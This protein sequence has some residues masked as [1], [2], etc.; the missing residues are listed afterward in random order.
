[1]LKS[2]RPLMVKCSSVLTCSQSAALSISQS[3]TKT[4]PMSLFAGILL[5]PAPPHRTGQYTPLTLANAF[6]VRFTNAKLCKGNYCLRKAD[7]IAF[8]TS[9]N[10]SFGSELLVAKCWHSSLILQPITVFVFH[11]CTHISKVRCL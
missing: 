9:M 2:C 6:P 7:V 8:F 10:W 5:H 11:H 4:L 1:M 3:F